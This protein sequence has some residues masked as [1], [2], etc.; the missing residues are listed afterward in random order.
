MAVEGERR[1]TRRKWN[2]KGMTREHEGVRTKAQ[3][4][5]FGII[6]RVYLHGQSPKQKDGEREREGW[7]KRIQ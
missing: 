6:Q 3:F 4:T 2:T 7:G 5:A 1:S